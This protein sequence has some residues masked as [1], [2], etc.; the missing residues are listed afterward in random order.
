MATR[1]WAQLKSASSADSGKAAGEV[2]AAQQ[3]ALPVN[4]VLARASLAGDPLVIVLGRIFIVVQP[5]LDPYPSDWTGENASN[6]GVRPRQCS[7]VVSTAAS[8]ISA[9]TLII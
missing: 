4:K 5:V 9:D 6:I 2:V 7:S 1:A 8:H 3:L